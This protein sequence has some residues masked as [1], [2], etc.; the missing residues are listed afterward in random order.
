MEPLGDQRGPGPCWLCKKKARVGIKSYLAPHLHN[1]WAL[2]NTIFGPSNKNL[3]K[4]KQISPNKKYIY[5]YNS[6]KI[7]PS[8]NYNKLENVLIY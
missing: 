7:N 5:I 4:K 3:P 2:T 8:Q 1:F 6:V